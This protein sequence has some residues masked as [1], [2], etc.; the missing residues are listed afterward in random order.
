ML[1]QLVVLQGPC[2]EPGLLVA[3]IAGVALIETR[4][5][6]I[7]GPALWSIVT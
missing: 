3:L 5:A 7:S 2:A 4:A 1:G 6:L